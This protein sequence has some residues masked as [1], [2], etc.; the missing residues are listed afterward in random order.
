LI[1]G[2]LV[3]KEIGRVYNDGIQRNIPTRG[4]KETV[5][6]PYLIVKEVTMEDWKRYCKEEYDMDVEDTQGF[7]YL[8]SID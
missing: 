5:N 6:T 4:I 3:R 7:F 2:T 8:V 1:L